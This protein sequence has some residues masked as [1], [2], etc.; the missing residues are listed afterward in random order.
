[1]SAVFSCH[2]KAGY[3]FSIANVWLQGVLSAEDGLSDSFLASRGV[4][5]PLLRLALSAAWPTV[6]QYHSDAIGRRLD[7][8]DND[9][10]LDRA[11]SGVIN[12]CKAVAAQLNTTPLF[13]YQVPC[14]MCPAS[15]APRCSPQQQT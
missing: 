7:L 2:S 3:R 6:F 15:H 11:V 10:H 14:D 12:P 5:T 8:S 13:L 9:T 4:K 1:M